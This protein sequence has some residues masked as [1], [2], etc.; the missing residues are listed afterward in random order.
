MFLWRNR[1]SLIFRIAGGGMASLIP[2][3]V[4]DEV[5]H[6]FDLVKVVSSYIELKKS[7]RNY[8]G[9]CPFHQE[10]TPSFMVSPE[11]QIF[12]C[13]GC[14]QGGNVISFVMEREGLS[15]PETVKYLARQAGIKVPERELTPAQKKQE[16]LKGELKRAMEITAQLYHI[17]LLKRDAG[18]R[19]LAYLAQRG[20]SEESIRAFSLGYAPNR[21]N[22][23]LEFAAKKGLSPAVLQK[24]GLV[25]SRPSGGYYDNFRGRIIFPINNLRG[26]VIG[27][28]G[29][30]L[31]EGEPKY[32]N[33]PQTVIYDKSKNLFGL[34]Q[35]RRAIR[36]KG[37]SIIMEGYMDVIIAHQNGVDN[38]VASLGTSLTAEQAGLLRVQTGEVVIAYDADT[39]GQAAT[40][41][42]LH[43]LKRAGCIV[44]IAELPTGMDPDD[45]IR[46]RGAA[47][48]QEQVL[49]KALPLTEYQL[50]K[51]KEQYGGVHDTQGKISYSK[52][53][54]KILAEIE[55]PLEREHYILKLEEEL[56]LPGD[57]LRREIRKQLQGK[58]HKITEKGK[59]NGIDKHVR[60]QLNPADPA[61]K[62]IISFVLQKPELIEAVMEAGLDSKDFSNEVFGSLMGRVM[63]LHRRGERLSIAKVFDYYQDKKTKEI[64]S[65]LGMEAG[66]EEH[67]E[68]KMLADC[69]KR[70]KLT[71]LNKER[72]NIEA[73]MQEMEKGKE[74]ERMNE[75]LLEWERL[76]KLE[77]SMVR[78]RERRE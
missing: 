1:N 59:T 46:Q 49:K 76:L 54:V 50:K 41:R 78:P 13:F 27:L 67:I 22:Y 56:S 55:Q 8:V 15:F 12:H 30:I 69:I 47:A 6:S 36:D 53:A 35:A 60:E 34:N 25:S 18:A 52:E 72:K 10:K 5:R 75:L 51:T 7:G 74:N 2:E 73:K 3:E 16:D 26:D 21:W 20:V 43:V 48:F 42:G 29:R 17:V 37:F 45:F 39:A 58:P 44:R 33:S 64:L 14:G 77:D 23:L 32:Y 4:V 9:L 68:K 62:T 65:N 66:I 24:A 70:I 71:K 19:A 31:G 38:A 11:K 57:T 61:E 63:D 40:W 28:G